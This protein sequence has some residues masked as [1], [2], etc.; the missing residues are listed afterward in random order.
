MK[1]LV[2]TSDYNETIKLAENLEE[3]YDKPVTFHCYWKW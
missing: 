1:L 2:K 3:D